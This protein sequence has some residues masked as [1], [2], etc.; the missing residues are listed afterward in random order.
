MTAASPAPGGGVLS[1]GY[2]FG[3]K[4]D[5]KS[6]IL[7]ADE[8]LVVHPAGHNVVLLNLETKAQQVGTETFIHFLQRAPTV[9][10]AV[11]C[12]DAILQLL[13]K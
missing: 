4:T 7:F 11:C 6:N 12:F 8:Q 1:H 9:G 13:L 10:A 5:V 3:L 2:L